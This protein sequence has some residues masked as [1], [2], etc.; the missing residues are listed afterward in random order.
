MLKMYSYNHLTIPI[1]FC[2]SLY[3]KTAHV[4]RTNSLMPIIVSLIYNRSVPQ[5]HVRFTCAIYRNR[6]CCSAYRHSAQL[7]RNLRYSPNVMRPHHRWAI[8]HV[9]V[10]MILYLRP[11]NVVHPTMSNWPALRC[12]RNK[13]GRRT[14]MHIITP[15]LSITNISFAARVVAVVVAVWVDVPITLLS[16]SQAILMVEAQVAP[17]LRTPSVCMINVLILMSIDIIAAV[18]T[19]WVEDTMTLTSNEYLLNYRMNYSSCI[20]LNTTIIFILFTIS[21]AI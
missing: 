3:A 5:W 6:I 12:T 16:A 4:Y 21:G 2:F 15:Q 13:H 7:I 18:E 1:I 14:N 8:T 17:S 19:F 20:I 10:L 11:H 9:H